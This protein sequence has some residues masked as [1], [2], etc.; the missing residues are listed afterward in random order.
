M[1]N[2]C[3]FPISIRFRKTWIILEKGYGKNYVD[4]TGKPE[5]NCSIQYDSPSLRTQDQ[6]VNFPHEN[7]FYREL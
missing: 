7:N 2:C 1:N 4:G 5:N 3:S 6:L